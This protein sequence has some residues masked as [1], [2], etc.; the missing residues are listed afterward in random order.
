MWLSVNAKNIEFSPTSA[1]SSSACSLNKNELPIFKTAYFWLIFPL[2]AILILEL[3][4]L[5]HW[6]RPEEW[7]VQL[8]ASRLVSRH[9]RLYYLL[10]R[11][12]VHF[13][14]LNIQPLDLWYY[15][16]FVS[17]FAD[18]NIWC[19]QFSQD[20]WRKG[21]CERLRR[22]KWRIQSRHQ[23]STSK[24]QMGKNSRYNMGWPA[25]GRGEEARSK[26]WCIPY[27]RAN[28]SISFV[29]VAHHA[30]SLNRTWATYGYFVR[31]LDSGN[32]SKR[33]SL[34]MVRKSRADFPISKCLCFWDE[35]RPQHPR[36]SIQPPDYIL[37]LRIS[38]WSNSIATLV[39][40]VYDSW[41]KLSLTMLTC[42][43]SVH[44]TTFPQWNSYGPSSHSASPQLNQQNR[45]LHC[46]SWLECWKVPLQWGL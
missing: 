30:D 1:F 38:R 12:S 43:K 44:H 24:R 36:K 18:P 35:R 19:H 3:Y 40:K 17:W 41:F 39:D 28:K 6:S 22:C 27:V 13:N 20:E 26:A 34:L 21:N 4:L 37:H 25:S 10:R 5:L 2:Q 29:Q 7:E 32:I 14:M 31:L 46:A 8:V 9:T 16:S 11:F 33:I 45:C 42:L 23:R 15:P